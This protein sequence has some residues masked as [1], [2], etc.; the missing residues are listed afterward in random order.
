[1]LPLS[2][3]LVP[4]LETALCRPHC[5]KPR[6]LFG[7]LTVRD[8]QVKLELALAAAALSRMISMFGAPPPDVPW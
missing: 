1:M 7:S 8:G 4:I 6:F 2:A 3:A 5:S